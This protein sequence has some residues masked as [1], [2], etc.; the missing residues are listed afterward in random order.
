MLHIK[1][2]SDQVSNHRNNG[3]SKK[4]TMAAT[5]VMVTMAEVTETMTEFTETIEIMVEEIT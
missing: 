1:H 4:K 3:T 5:E 2:R